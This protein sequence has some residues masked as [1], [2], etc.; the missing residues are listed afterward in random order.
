[1][2][3]FQVRGIQSVALGCISLILV[4]LF[5]LQG[6]VEAA[7]D[8][9]LKCFMTGEG[10]R[11]CVVEGH[12]L[13]EQITVRIENGDQC[14]TSIERARAAGFLVLGE[15]TSKSDTAQPSSEV[16]PAA[17]VESP[18]ALPEETS[19]HTPEAALPVPESEPEQ[20]Q[21]PAA[22]ESPAVPDQQPEEAGKEVA[23]EAPSASV[24]DDGIS[25]SD[26]EKQELIAKMT[27][28]SLSMTER[29]QAYQQLINR[30]GL[31]EEER[32]GIEFAWNFTSGGGAKTLAIGMLKA[33]LLGPVGIGLLVLLLFFIVCGWIIF[34]KADVPGIL[35][36]IPIVNVF[37]MVK[38]AGKPLWWFILLFIPVVNIIISLLLCLALAE[39][40]G[41][42]ALMGL[43]LFFLPFIGLPILAFS[44][45]Y[46]G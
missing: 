15:P 25:Q 29:E 40:F 16:I 21:E 42:G 22:P 11:V 45:E 17:P 36:L 23:E 27:D 13:Y 10:T 28:D 30:P 18:E 44:G 1:M 43:V 14:L 2:M 34:A 35:S 31:T 20:T 12:R 39:R 32:Q 26:R 24:S 8:C 46:Q 41:K 33:L 9:Y 5:A 38:I 4:S 19:E 3:K 6:D 37:F 7:S